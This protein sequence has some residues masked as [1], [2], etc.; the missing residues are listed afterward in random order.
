MHTNNRMERHWEETKVFIRKTWPKFTE[1]EL[2]RINGNY[3]KFMGYLR[4][5]YNDFPR[6]EALARDKMQYFLNAMDAKHPER[7]AVDR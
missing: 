7:T 3:D 4:E 5:F 1:V 6:S 2:S